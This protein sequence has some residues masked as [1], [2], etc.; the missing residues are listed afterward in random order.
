MTATDAPRPLAGRP[1][2][3]TLVR[4]ALIVNT[5]IALSLAYVALTE[6]QVGTGRYTLYGLLWVGAGVAAVAFTDVSPAG[7]RARRVAGAVAVGYLGAL[8]V[9]GGLVGPGVP[10][11]SADGLRVATLPPGWG[12]A[13]VYGGTTLSAVLMPA[14]VVGYLA[15]AYL[16]YA[17]VVD[18][19][20]VSD[21]AVRGTVPG[22]LGL[23][24][25]VSCSWPILASL[26]TG[27]FGAGTAVAGTALALSYDLSTLVYLVTVGLLYWR[28]F[29]P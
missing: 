23:L 22:L 6:A 20:A 19:L 8:A 16:V 28:P 5:L 26:A 4:L 18:A 7:V 24:S 13:L 29:G 2:R 10:P 11:A 17:T 9:A 14:K 27:V 12:P 15:L 21:G 25:C 3:E 1:T